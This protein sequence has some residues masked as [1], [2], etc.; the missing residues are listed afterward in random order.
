[1]NS[2]R[3]IVGSSVAAAALIA[4]PFVFA[5]GPP[6]GTTPPNNNVSAPI[7]VG[8]S[9]QVKNA[10]L[11]V[12]ALT[13][14]GNGVLTG[15]LGVG[16]S[17]VPGYPLDVTGN[18]RVTGNVTAAGFF[19]SSDAR[20]KTNIQTAAGLSIIEKL[21]GVTFE[22]KK[23]NTPSAGVIAQ[24]VEIVMPSAVHT[25]ASGYKTVEYD[26]LIGQL[27]EAIKQQ[28]VQIDTLSHEVDTSKICQ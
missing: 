2:S 7:N 17:N 25:D 13:V 21:R 8:S 10:G 1:M 27:I 9:D 4:A 20:L 24:E 3:L 14:F 18:A 28:Q 15:S 22:W 6:P 19:H 23:D 26:Q 11:S 16:S 5:W 12:N